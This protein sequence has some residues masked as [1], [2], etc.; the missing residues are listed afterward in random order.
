[1][2]SAEELLKQAQALNEDEKY[3]EVTT[4]L[5]DEKL[6]S[7]QNADLF[8]E[9]AQA[10]WRLQENDLCDKNAEMA[11]LINP[12]HAKANHYKGNIY[13][14]LK[15]YDEAIDCYNVAIKTD[16][17][18]IYPYISLGV[19]YHDLKDYR[20]VIEF[21]NKAIE[22]DYD[23]DMVYNNLGASYYDLKE[24]EKAKEFYDKYINLTKGNPNYFT[25][26]A[27]SRIVEL[28]KLIYSS[29]YESISDLVNKIKNLLLFKDNCITHYTSLSVTKVLILKEESLFRL[30]EGAFL[31]DTSEGRELFDFLPPLFAT[32]SRV[33][34]TEAKPFTSKPFVGSFVSQKKH[35][36][37]TLWRM[38][39]KENK[40][41][42][43]GC[44][45][46]I[47]REKL[48]Q[49]I[50][51]S[52]A[53]D[54]K[55]SSLEK[56]DEEFNFYRVAY[57]Q[58]DNNAHFII[59]GAPDEEQALNG[60][61]TDLQNK[62]DCFLEKKI[63]PTETQ[64]L[65]ELLNRIAFLFKSFE[66]Q[67]EH[68]IRLVVKGVGFEKNVDTNFDPPRVYINLVGIRPL[69]ERI[70][71]GPKVE[72]AEEWASAFYYSLDKQDLHPEILISHLPFK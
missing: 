24:Y 67:Y 4:L 38:Y 14:D 41:E 68:E 44:A 65:M 50:K 21:C 7:Y 20:K 57:R 8:A 46:T 16:P 3:E 72:K 33:N 19:V 52:L 36:D 40:E 31:N 18:F 28:N 22:L 49:G 1:M 13:S 9:K 64:S 27:K 61:M 66:Y 11:L 43:R 5:P 32:A 25:E 71:L 51:N 10:Y 56:T 26:L 15:R 69:I 63:D 53:P 55:T 2:L 42:A 45:I 30:S 6:I 58:Q 12:L 60:L 62:I 59:P 35:D 47:E 48:L 34:D 23:N 37:L 29:D 54:N 70:T 39:G 17:N